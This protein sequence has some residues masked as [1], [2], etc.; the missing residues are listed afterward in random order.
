MAEITSLMLK[1]AFNKTPEEALQYFKDKGI[2]VSDNFKETIKVIEDDCF[3]ISKVADMDIL[4][5]FKDLIEQAIKDGM[6]VN[7]FKK[8]IKEKLAEKGWTGR[9]I[10]TVPGQE[11]I[12]NPWRLNLIYRQNLQDAYMMGRL[13]RQDEVADVFPYAELIAVIDAV[14]TPI[15]RGLNGIIMLLSE[16]KSSGRYPPLHF[17]CRTRARTITEDKAKSKGISK[18]EEYQHVHP[19]EGFDNL[20]GQF[21]PNLKNYPKELVEEYNKI[22]GG[23]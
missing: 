15:C 6:T 12:D 2:A 1:T 21:K 4:V 23:D 3:T 14:T 18:T 13:Q 16:L 10:S 5:D 9:N 11:T 8:Q 22:V 17:D 7:D 20:P 19:A